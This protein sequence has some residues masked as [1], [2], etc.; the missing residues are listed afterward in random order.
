MDVIVIF[1]A[2]Y[3]QPGGRYRKL[4]EYARIDADLAATLI[5]DGIARLIRVVKEDEP[6]E[7]DGSE[8][9]TRG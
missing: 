8:E 3:V 7:S 6:E 9:E 5:A 4:G 2:P 1:N